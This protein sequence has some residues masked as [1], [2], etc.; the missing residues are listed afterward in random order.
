MRQ[1]QQLTIGERE[2]LQIGLWEGRS[3][4]D[5]AAE[6]GRSHATL[7]REL[8]K[9]F[10]VGRCVYTPRL[11][12]MRAEI[13]VKQRG[14]RPRLKQDSIR[15]YVE[16]KLKKRWSPE[17]IAGRM[18]RDHP[19]W[20]SISHEAIYQYV[21]ADISINA[22]AHGDD[23]RQ[24]LRRHH[25]IRKRKGVFHGNRGP[26]AGRI[27]IEARP[28][29][30]AKRTRYG[31]WEHDSIE[32][33]KSKARLNSLVE[34]KSGLLRLT[35]IADGIAERTAAAVIKRL[36]TLPRRL[37]RTVTVDNGYE[38]AQHQEIT[39]AID[40]EYFFC[41]PYCSGEKGTNENTNG[42][43][44][45][46][47]PKGTDFALVSEAEVARVERI[48]NCRPRKRLSYLTP[49]EVFNEAVALKD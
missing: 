20:P 25:R 32:S 12:Q 6:L 31:D 16:V 47:L 39:K 22:Y 3:L 33:R 30:V 1:Y 46:Y 43:V 37:R 14:R 15:Q 18:K 27:S 17:Q 48:L 19:D 8:R 28:V 24:Y 7:S 49:L 40:I 34:R 2:K 42:L 38:N 5:I 29:E 35:K 36:K 45:E 26:I 10:P 21:Y 9:N 44:R 13:H 4:R 23:L 41:H 11:A